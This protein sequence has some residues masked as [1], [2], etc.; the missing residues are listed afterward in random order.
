MHKKILKGISEQ[1]FSKKFL[2]GDCRCLEN[3]DLTYQQVLTLELSEMGC[4]FL[5]CA[6]FQL[7]GL[8]LYYFLRYL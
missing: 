4:S 5:S 6:F 1:K 7:E 3:T 8:S 2:Q